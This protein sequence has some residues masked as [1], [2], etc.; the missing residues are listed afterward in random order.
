[1]HSMVRVF[2]VV[3]V[4]LAAVDPAG[5]GALSEIEV[6]AGLNYGYL[7][8]DDPMELWDPGWAMGFTGGVFFEMP[9]AERVSFVPGL[10]FSSMKNNVELSGV[11]EGEFNVNHK[12]ISIPIL[13]RVEL[14]ENMFFLDAGPEFSLFLSTEIQNDY[15]DLLDIENNETD[16]ISDDIE[17]YNIGACIR[18]GF[19]AY[20]WDIP[21]AVTASYH[22]GFVGV[23]DED[24]WWSDWKTREFTLCVS[25]LFDLTE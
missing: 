22:H 19:K 7:C 21:V 10:R 8:Y 18:V 11:Y 20:R 14:G 15:K 9:L 2:L 12:Y 4:L 13:M 1:M 25:Y 23:A 16:D 17:S 6:G 24:E 3:L 5:A